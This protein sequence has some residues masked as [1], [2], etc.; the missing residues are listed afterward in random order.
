MDGSTGEIPQPQ[1]PATRA[2][3]PKPVISTGSVS[4]REASTP[5]TPAINPEAWS[6]HTQSY[7]SFYGSK[8]P[9]LDTQ[10]GKDL[11]TNYLKHAQNPIEVIKGAEQIR[12]EELRQEQL[13]SAPTREQLTQKWK[14][15]DTKLGEQAL[16]DIT[17]YAQGADQKEQQRVQDEAQIYIAFTKRYNNALANANIPQWRKDQL[18]KE[19]ELYNTALQELPAEVKAKALG[20]ETTTAPRNPQ[21][22]EDQA[23]VT[24]RLTMIK[25]INTPEGEEQVRQELHTMLNVQPETP[26]TPA[27]V[28]QTPD[29]VMGNP[30]P[31]DSE[32][33]ASD[34]KKRLED[35]QQEQK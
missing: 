12:L 28:D 6:K 2:E 3:A 17:K 10:R 11:Y 16:E 27:E 5:A 31:K 18:E 14:Q 15:E 33:Q 20:Q 32:D 7:E 13:K 22:S 25:D 34:W 21:N 4:G 1:Q 24:Q 30:T 8:P 9:S 26:E 19:K 23:G 29:M 35:W